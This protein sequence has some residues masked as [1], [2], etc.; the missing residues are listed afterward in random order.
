MGKYT[1]TITWVGFED[2]MQNERRQTQR[3]CGIA[4]FHLHEI[5][6]IGKVIVR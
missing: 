1:L 3:T 2:V 5:S 4:W 6:K